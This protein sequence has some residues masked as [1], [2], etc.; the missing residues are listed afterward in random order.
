MGKDAADA[1]KVEF[2]ARKLP[3]GEPRK[4][5]TYDQWM[6]SKVRMESIRNA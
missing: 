2:K 5:K 1:L 3:Y 4:P 6:A